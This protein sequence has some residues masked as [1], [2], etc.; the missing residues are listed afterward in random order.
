[1]ES[2]AEYT[3]QALLAEYEAAAAD[4]RAAEL[5]FWGDLAVDLDDA[6]FRA[7]FEKQYA[8][9]WGWSCDP[10]TPCDADVEGAAAHL[11]ERLTNP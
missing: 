5:A 2:F 8:A 1:M 3:H 7:A 11:E 10:H 4:A 6:V 9:M